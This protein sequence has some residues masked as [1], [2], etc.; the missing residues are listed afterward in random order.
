MNMIQHQDPVW[1]TGD[2]PV[3][4]MPDFNG[5]PD[6]VTP[7]EWNPDNSSDYDTSSSS[8]DEEITLFPI[9]HHFDAAMFH[10]RELTQ[11]AYNSFMSHNLN[12]RDPD[13]VPGGDDPE[14]AVESEVEEDTRPST[15]SSSSSTKD[16]D[17]EEDV[18]PSS[19]SATKE[20][21]KYYD[22]NGNEIT[23]AQFDQQEAEREAAEAAQK[24]KD[25]Q[26][27]TTTQNGGKKPKPV[28]VAPTGGTTTTTQT[29]EDFETSQY[30]DSEGRPVD[31]N[32]VV[33]VKKPIKVTATTNTTQT[34]ESDQYYDSEGRPV[35]NHTR[36]RMP[37]V[38][39]GTESVFG[40]GNNIF[41]DQNYNSPAF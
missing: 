17:A 30:Y 4:Q 12:D 15:S 26:A 8:S 31:A 6:L 36:R 28:K 35:D 34:E 9:E 25:Q 7:I 37:S 23:K 13:R 38:L 41:N 14:Q 3:A 40:D 1:T 11:L 33:I 24:L 20:A 5:H 27:A 29:A 21:D 18:R 10:D 2:G 39:D 32:G 16:D 22:Y 19:S